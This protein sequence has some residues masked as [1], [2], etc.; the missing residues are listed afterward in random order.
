L[1]PEPNVTVKPS[2]SRELM[3]VP[4]VTTPPASRRSLRVPPKEVRC[5]ALL[6]SAARTTT[7]SGEK[8][9]P[10]IDWVPPIPV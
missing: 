8:P 4:G 1:E 2:A 6:P 5:E 10:V 3:P 7:Y 9:R